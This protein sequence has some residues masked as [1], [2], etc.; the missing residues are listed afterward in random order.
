MVRS[1]QTMAAVQPTT[2]TDA[3]SG[4]GSCASSPKNGNTGG[5]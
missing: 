5:G 2:Q 1:D 4:N 3:T